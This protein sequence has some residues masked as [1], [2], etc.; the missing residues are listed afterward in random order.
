MTTTKPTPDGKLH[1]SRDSRPAGLTAREIADLIKQA[2]THFQVNQLSDAEK[3]Y[4]HLAASTVPNRTVMLRLADIALKTGRLD[5]SQQFLT[6]LRSHFPS[7]QWL[8]MLEGDL[9]MARFELDAAISSYR[10]ALRRMPGQAAVQNRLSNAVAEYDREHRWTAPT[11]LQVWPGKGSSR[12]DEAEPEDRVLV[13]SWDIAHNV[14]GRGITLAETI[15]EEMPTAVAG[16]MFPVHGDT[17]WEPLASSDRQVPVIGWS[18]PFFRHLVEGALRL[19]RD[20]PATTV[21]V[22]K[23]RFPG[24]LIGLLYRE[25]LGARI[26]CDIDD[27]ELAFVKGEAPRDFESFLSDFDPK[28]WKRPQDRIWTEL[29][30]GILPFVDG[31]TACNPVLA[32][33]YDATLVRHGRRTADGEDAIKRRHAMRSKLGFTADD[34]VV[35]F[36]G[37]PRRHKG[38]VEL[39][40]AVVALNRP[41]VVLCIVG[42]V[43]DPDMERDLENL[44]G[45]RLRRI[46]AQPFDQVLDLNATADVV[47]LLQDRESAISK[48]QTPAKLTDAVAVGTPV[49]ITDVA[50]VADIIASG[51]AMPL[52]K[53]EALTD[54]LSDALAAACEPRK[55]H[56][57]FAKEMSYEANS[58]RA[59]AAIEM[60]RS[61]PSRP[62]PDAANLL[63]FIRREMPGVLPP[64]LSRLATPHSIRSTSDAL[65]I[66]PD[67]PI[68]VAFFWKQNDS[69]LYGRRQDML[70]RELASRPEIG[71]ILHVDAPM[72]VTDLYFQTNPMRPALEHERSLVSA[73]TLARLSGVADEGKIH[74]RSFVCGEDT[75]TLLGRRVPAPESFPNAVEAW[76]DDLGMRDNCIAWA[77][78]IVPGFEDVQRRLRFP[79]I[80]GDFIDDQRFWPQSDA[81]KRQIQKNYQFMT[82]TVDV[83]VANC[84]PVAQGL[85]RDGLSPL[86]VPNGIDIRSQAPEPAPE[87]SR[88]NGPIIGYTGNMTARFDFDLVEAIACARPHW[89]IV[90]IGKLARGVQH[91]RMQALANVHLLGIRPYEQARACIA[92]FDVAIIPHE[93]NDLSDR[94]NPLKLYV[95]RSLGVPVV[96]T[97]IANIDELRD[98]LTV[99]EGPDGFVRMIEA[100]MERQAR[101]GRVYPTPLM[102]S[103][104]SWHARMETIWAEVDRRLRDRFSGTDG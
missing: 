52:R 76:L 35:L 33:Q 7:E 60:A 95:Y 38:L 6:E 104:L 98:E 82:K 70:L 73:S 81:S 64:E 11:E 102:A 43:A 85:E 42:S 44:P 15:C 26:L 12:F 27:D 46:G 87:I 16:P 4:E 13:V 40:H 100:A 31:I 30:L 77:C 45:L 58:L 10:E 84:L 17:L 5:R 55:P 63:A 93:R 62:Y 80:V 8:P 18:T 71:R 91:D 69:G 19:V 83:A 1:E 24:L 86:L 56:P 65:R 74:R 72:P 9:A 23:P 57:F 79:F 103:A 78:P 53:D 34:K 3:V 21:W 75:H 39:A 29:G 36:L 14:V 68:N 48:A 51:A 25:I 94:M 97:D 54:R 67:R 99:A 41:E 89:Q 28:D 61:K 50:P 88:L 90:L 22:S 2:N 66:D 49:L 47:V 92:A 37:T 20:Y 101:D 96:S 59:R 32:K